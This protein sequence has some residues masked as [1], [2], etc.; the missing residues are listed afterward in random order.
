MPVEVGQVY[1]SV[2]PV[3]G[4]YVELRVT[5]LCETRPGVVEVIDVDTGWSRLFPVR[6]LHTEPLGPRGGRLRSGYV[7]IK[8]S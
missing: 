3:R 8:E 5:A 2:G 1:R 6:L 7:L 4:R